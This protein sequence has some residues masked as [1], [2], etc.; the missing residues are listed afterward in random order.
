MATESYEFEATHLLKLAETSLQ[1]YNNSI[2]SMIC[3]YAGSA[4]DIMDFGAGIGFLTGKVRARGLN[5]S[6]VEL[7]RSNRAT[8]IQIGFPTVATLEEVPL[9]SL[10]FIY[11]SNV[12][13]HIEDDVETLIALRE[14]LRPG[15][16]LLLYV[17]AFQSLYSSMDKQVGHF[18]R[19]DRASL[20]DKLR[21]AN[22]K[23]EDM[24][25]TDVL[26]YFATRAFQL[27]GNNMSHASLLSLQ[28]YD[29]FVFP[30]GHLIER[31]VRV[32]VGKNIVA[33][34]RNV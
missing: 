1:N 7:D 19:Y 30:V 28:I 17:P 27:S 23:I 11:S 18:R 20:G 14:R 3:R 34:A 33:V 13:E 6:C 24:F 2:A 9:G 10:D 32:P 22:F 26:G 25:Y 8:L 31:L 5:P 4:R 16:G 21:E 15:G 12:L 29:R